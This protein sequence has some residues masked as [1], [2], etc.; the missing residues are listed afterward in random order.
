MAVEV[1]GCWEF[2]WQAPLNEYDLWIHP[3]KEFNVSEFTMTPITG[4]QKGK[5]TEVADINEVINNTD[6][7]VVFVDEAA[8]V[9]LDEFEHPANAMYVMGKTSFSPYVT[10]FDETKHVAVK[11]PSDKNTG[12]FWGHQAISMILY[13]RYIKT[14]K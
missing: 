12:G 3:I 10:S 9:T 13:D 11:I 1:V 2:A 7:T 6:K 4:I 14:G 8:D 5:V